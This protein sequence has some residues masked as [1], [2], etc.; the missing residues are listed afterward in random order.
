MRSLFYR[1]QCHCMRKHLIQ[2][3]DSDWYVQLTSVSFFIFVDRSFSLRPSLMSFE[4]E[5][6]NPTL[7]H[8]DE[9]L[10]YQMW[11]ISTR[12]RSSIFISWTIYHWMDQLIWVSPSLRRNVISVKSGGRNFK[13]S[14]IARCN[15]LM[16]TLPTAIGLS[17]GSIARSMIWSMHWTCVKKSIAYLN[18]DIEW[19]SSERAH[20]LEGVGTI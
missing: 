9:H 10:L 14:S 2:T 7:I 1:V 13:V 6:S 11:P 20:G 18:E 16:G 5:K 17:E 19:R 12:E 3:I 15:R 8:S 4:R